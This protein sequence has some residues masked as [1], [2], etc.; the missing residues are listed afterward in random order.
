[1]KLICD[2]LNNYSEHTKGDEIMIKEHVCK[3]NINENAVAT[4]SEHN[5]V[6]YYFNGEKYYLCCLLPRSE[7]DKD[8]R[9]D[10]TE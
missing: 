7:C 2:N 1:M 4:M 3:T 9:D 5:D 8:H 10:I 6:K